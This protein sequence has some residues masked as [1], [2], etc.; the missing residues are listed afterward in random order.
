PINSCSDFS[1]ACS[2]G[3][4]ISPV[5][6]NK[7]RMEVRLTNWWSQWDAALR[8]GPRLH[9]AFAGRN[10]PL[11]DRRSA[12]RAKIIQ[13]LLFGQNPEQPLPDRHRA[14][15]LFAIKT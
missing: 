12:F 3:T 7:T 11:A 1:S 13:D 4:P 6:V 10:F 8:P 14:F 5:P 2:V 9:H 15:T